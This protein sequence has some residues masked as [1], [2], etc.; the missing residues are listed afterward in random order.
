MH[1]LAIGCRSLRQR[2]L[3]DQPVQSAHEWPQPLRGVEVGH[4]M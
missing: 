1:A 4:V 3:L 2:L